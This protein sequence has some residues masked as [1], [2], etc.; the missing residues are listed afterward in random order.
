MNYRNYQLVNSWHEYSLSSSDWLHKALDTQ[1]A[2]PG[3]DNDAWCL[4]VLVSADGEREHVWQRDAQSTWRW[5][6]WLHCQWNSGDGEGGY[7]TQTHKVPGDENNDSTVSG[8]LAM[9]KR[10]MANGG[11]KEMK[12]QP[13]NSMIVM[14]AAFQFQRGN[15][16]SVPHF[17]D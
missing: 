9:V 12:V 6:Q 16:L 3:V 7:D 17:S 2:V 11:P 4:L 14:T 10:N 13:K 5:E 8:S 1:T 15:R